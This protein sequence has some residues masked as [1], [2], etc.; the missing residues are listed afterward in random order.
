MININR[1]YFLILFLGLL[2]VDIM[3]DKLMP[4]LL[5][6]SVSKLVVLISDKL[7]NTFLRCLS[8]EDCVDWIYMEDQK[9]PISWQSAK[10][11]M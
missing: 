8:L 10:F 7:E 3:G 1:Y 9:H 4:A 5:F 2:F 11:Y 6:L